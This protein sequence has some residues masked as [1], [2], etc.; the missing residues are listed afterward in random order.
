M[1]KLVWFFAF[2]SLNSFAAQGIV[3]VLEAP[4][5]ATEDLNST[6]VQYVRKGD[7]IYIHD[8]A[9]RNEDYVAVDTI[10][11][12]ENNIKIPSRK[13]E[14][15]FYATIDKQGNVVFVPKK[16][17]EVLFQDER[18]LSQA[19]PN[20]D[21]TDYR[22][23]EPLP[24]GYP[25]YSRTGFRSSFVLGLGQNPK[26]NYEY[27]RRIAKEKQGNLIEVSGTFTSKAEFDT[28]N[29]TYFGGTFNYYTYQ[30]SYE[31]EDA[32]AKES[33]SKFGIGPYFSYDP[34]VSDNYRITLYTSLLYNLSNR[35]DVSIVENSGVSDDRTFNGRTFMAK[36]GAFINFTDLA[37][38]SAENLDLITGFNVSKEFPSTLTSTT[39][40]KERRLWNQDSGDTIANAGMNFVLFAG[41]QKSF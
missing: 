13:T 41:I 10:F 33:E 4:L 35:H 39:P 26:N 28:K 9:L 3:Q 5:F 8:S 25:L 15:D 2:F 34:M 31:L 23:R 12:D 38:E 1:K 7:K 30:S 20:P 17:V 18:E 32:S 14:S 11:N 16:Y 37:S 36:V 29:R 22:L 19:K 24:K 21:H 6:V 27:N 40:A